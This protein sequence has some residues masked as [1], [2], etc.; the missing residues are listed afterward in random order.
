MGNF[1]EC[2]INKDILLKVDQYGPVY[3]YHIAKEERKAVFAK[4]FSKNK[5]KKGNTEFYYYANYW[6]LLQMN[7]VASL[8]RGWPTGMRGE[9]FMANKQSL[10]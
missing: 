6:A 8:D 10:K 2:F 3:A 7:W 9:S 4:L 5:I 1:G